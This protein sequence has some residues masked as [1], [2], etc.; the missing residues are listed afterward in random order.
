MHEL[1]IH[2]DENGEL[3]VEL[4]LEFTGEVT[5]AEAHAQADAFE[6]QVR[7]SWPDVTSLVT[8]LEPLAK[9]FIGLDA[10]E[11]LPPSE[12][13]MALVTKIVSAEQVKELRMYRVGGH[14]HA[15]IVLTFPGEMLLSEVHHQAEESGNS[16][17]KLPAAGGAC[18]CAYGAGGGKRE[19]LEII[20]PGRFLKPSGSFY[21]ADLILRKI[22]SL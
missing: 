5:L 11:D 2:T 4:H 1:H 3:I 17:A 14:L 12:D 7:R 20:R 9:Y 22:L 16:L 19:F 18:H 10:D 21:A 8:H 15:N 6:T 13:V